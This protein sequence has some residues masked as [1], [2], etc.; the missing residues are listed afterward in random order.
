MPNGMVGRC[1]TPL[2]IDSH[3]RQ[4]YFFI[5]AYDPAGRQW[6]QLWAIPQAAYT[7]GGPEHADTAPHTM[8]ITSPYTRDEHRKAVSWQKIMDRLTG[9]A[10]YLLAPRAAAE[11]LCPLC[12]PLWH[13][14]GRDDTAGLV[15]G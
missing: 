1:G 14:G 12:R 6:N 8:V 3:I 15:T 13:N 4:S 9:Y 11:G 7:F 5:E 2:H 10:E